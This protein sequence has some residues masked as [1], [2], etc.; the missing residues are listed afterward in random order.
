MA[1]IPQPIPV[2][3]TLDVNI[4]CYFKEDL[5][6]IIQNFVVNCNPYIMVSWKIPEKFN[7]PFIDSND[8]LV[9]NP[10]I[11]SMLIT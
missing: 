1:K 5:D 3:L 9:I 11:L 6:Q 7:M 4:I 8:P 2:N 10:E